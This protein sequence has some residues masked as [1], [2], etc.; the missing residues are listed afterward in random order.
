[1]PTVASMIRSSADWYAEFVQADDLAEHYVDTAWEQR[2]YRLRDFYLGYQGD[3]AVG[4]LSLQY[5]GDYAYIGYLYLDT[6]FVGNGYGRDFLDF[7]MAQARQKGKKGVVLIAH[8]QATW[9]VKA[10]ERYGFV[11]HARQPE[12]ILSWNQGALKPYYEAGFHL[13]LYDLQRQAAAAPASKKL[14]YH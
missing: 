12:S 8:P 5:F 4:T 1:M 6:R 2:N 9:A 11:C 10:Y 14:V 13:Y 7:A 3:T